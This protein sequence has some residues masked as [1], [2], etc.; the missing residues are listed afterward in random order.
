MIAMGRQHAT[1]GQALTLVL[2]ISCA[3]VEPRADFD[4]ARE[5]VEESTGR[6]EV[7]DPYAPA[8]TAEELEA[9][10]AD[11]LSLDE[12]LR[13]A[14]VNNRDL[15]AEFQEIGVAHADWVQ[16]RLLSN[17]SLDVLLRFP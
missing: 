7:F 13:L 6:D 3:Q 14:L 8:L 10:L 2:A 1:I 4:Q 12:A 15:Q 5:L 11:G 16:S 9:I 17:P